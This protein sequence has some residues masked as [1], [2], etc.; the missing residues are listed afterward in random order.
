MNQ[1]E[2]LEKLK[3]ELEEEK[4]E[5]RGLSTDITT[6]NNNVIVLFIIAFFLI[7]AYFGVLFVLNHQN[8]QEHKDIKQMVIDYQNPPQGYTEECYQEETTEKYKLIEAGERCEEGCEWTWLTVINSDWLD[9]SDCY[10]EFDEVSKNYRLGCY[11]CNEVCNT[12]PFI[13]Y[14]NETTCAKWVMVRI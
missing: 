12:E 7:F 9:W 11:D 1:K 6:I 8:L 5:R 14:Y 4:F 2:E 13:E 3:E 10:F